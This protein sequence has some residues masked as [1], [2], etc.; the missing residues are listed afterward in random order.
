MCNGD[1]LGPR[2]AST[3]TLEEVEFG[4]PQDGY[5]DFWVRFTRD[6]Q[7]FRLY[8]SCAKPLRIHRRNLSVAA[9]EVHEKPDCGR[10]RR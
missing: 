3:A 10:G 7:P 8:P 5:P 4:P 6:N 9:I 1:D 2:V